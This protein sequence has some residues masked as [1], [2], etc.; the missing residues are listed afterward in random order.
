MLLA[1]AFTIAMLGSIESLLSAVVADG[2]TGTKHD[3]N[4]ELIGQGIANVVAPLFGGFAATGAIART[5]TNVRNGATSPLA[6]IVHVLVLVLIVVVAAPLAENIPLAALAAVLFVVAYNMSEWRHFLHIVRGAPVADTAILLI[7]FVLTVFADLVV[8][9]NVG[10][11]LAS[12]LFM[13]R[14]AQTVEV[15]A[16]GAELISDELTRLGLPP[17]P[18]GVQVFTI[19][20]PFFFGAAEHFQR[21]LRAT[22]Q[23]YHTLVIRLGDVPFIDI[24]GILTLETMILQQKKQGIR[25]IFCG[26]NSKVKAKL[27]KAGIGQGDYALTFYDRLQDTLYDLT[28]SP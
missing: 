2:M 3:S 16:Q 4:Q 26:A 24:T 10:V 14:M 20:G 1:P 8:A 23:Q 9:V 25:V 17:L 6:G 11:I 19:D 27:E 28:G 5:A 7:T 21:A 18:Q 12:L 22:Q 15:R 13:R